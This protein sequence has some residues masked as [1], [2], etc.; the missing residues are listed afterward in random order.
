MR[1][2]DVKKAI[3]VSGLL[4]VAAFGSAQAQQALDTSMYPAAPKGMVQHIFTLPEQADEALYRVEIVAGKTM[5]GDCNHIMI[6]ADLDREDVDG[7]GYSYYEIDDVSQPASTMMGCAD[8]TKTPRFVELNFGDD[9][10]VDYNSK[11][12][13]VV[14]APEDLK[15]G[16]RLWQSNGD[17]LG[18]SN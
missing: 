11:L 9:A 13:L 6:G 14:Y 17:I 3:L 10:L 16:Y 12:P 2:F 7:W 15:L 8:A 18:M 5:E 4:C 1:G